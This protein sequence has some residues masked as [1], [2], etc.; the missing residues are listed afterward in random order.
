MG[1]RVT[2]IQRIAR[3]SERGESLSLLDLQVVYQGGRFH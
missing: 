1:G 3:V 2:E